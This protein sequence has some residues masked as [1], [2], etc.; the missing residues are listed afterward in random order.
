MYQHP[1]T[2]NSAVKDISI[3]INAIHRSMKDI[4]LA[5]NKEEINKTIKLIQFNDSLIN[6][7]FQIIEDRFLGDK[8]MI[9]DTHN[10]YKD[11]GKIRNE[12]IQ[13]RKEDKILAAAN[14]TKGKGAIHVKMLLGKIKT[15]TDFAQN[16]ADEFY[17]KTKNERNKGIFALLIVTAVLLILSIIT[18]FII[19]KSI[20]KPI[21]KFIADISLIFN[22]KHIQG[23][24]LHLISEE[25]ILSYTALELKTSYDNLAKFNLELEQLVGERTIE[26]IAQNKELKIANKKTVESEK[27]FSKAISEAPFPIMIHSEGEVL[28]LSNSWTKITGYS[29]KDIPTITKWTE[30]A[31]GKKAILSK[32]FINELYELE[33]EKYDGEWEITTSDKNK[34]IWEFMSTPLGKYP[35]GRRII[36]SM[37]V[38][39]TERKK[40]EQQLI[41]AK[42][43]AEESD[44]LKSAFLANMSHE[45]RTP[46]NGI[47]GFSE[48][49]KN[50]HLSDSKQQKYI[51]VIEK[52]GNR[53]LNI[54]NDIVDISKIEAGLM[55]VNLNE[56]NINEQIEYIYTFFKPE[57]EKKGMQFFFK[58]TLSAKEATIKTDREKL[59]A[60]LTNLVKNAIKYSNE[61]FIEFGYVLKT[62][63]NGAELNKKAELEFFIKDTG[64]GVSK[65]RQAAIFERFIQADIEDTMARQGAG[66]GLSITKAYIEILGGKIWVESEETIGSTFYFTLPYNV[67]LKRKNS[68]KEIEVTNNTQNHGKNLKVLIAED[69][70][71]SLE[72]LSTIIGEFSHEIIKASNGTEAVEICRNNPDIDLILM[73][74]QMPKMN[75]YEA[76]N[77]IRKFNKD[78]I[79]IAQTAYGLTGDREKSLDAGCNDYI[80]KPIN[81]SELDSL[82]QKYFIL[83]QS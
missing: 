2:V 44:K 17:D 46:M 15:L 7:S 74:I 28:M 69:D 80:T 59:F 72:L 38:D 78:V 31:Y 39:I 67:E 6:I 21:H 51:E 26:L 49:L 56:S 50:P 62:G 27:R 73:D 37:A 35:N 76:T 45:I 65:D 43:K 57:V 10:S 33:K 4:A 60:I 8:I 82:I 18:A 14:I 5:E 16:K 29:K 36:S 63:G 30:K 66:L 19:S 25:E 24:D 53:M 32:E 40:G 13:L 47:L 48:L 70:E 11:W 41:N 9:E 54:I 52:S 58:N 55:D 12:V 71:V 81:K 75:G 79:I 23:V 1:F 68:T 77:Q 83:R 3:N 42:E 20:S 22:K 64:I 61:G 34:R